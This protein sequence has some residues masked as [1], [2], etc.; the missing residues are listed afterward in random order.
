M[1]HICM[2]RVLVVLL[3]LQLFHV[4]LPR[5]HAMSLCS[6]PVKKQ[7]MGLILLSFMSV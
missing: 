7:L 5:D 2:Y 6:S 3:E 1:Y 4:H